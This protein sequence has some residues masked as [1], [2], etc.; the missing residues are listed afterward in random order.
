[1][2]AETIYTCDSCG[3]KIENYMVR[4]QYELRA[5]DGCGP[6]EYKS[7]DLHRDCASEI[8]ADLPNAKN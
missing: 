4:V 5:P 2:S 6:G 7:F 1:M 3:K 8:K